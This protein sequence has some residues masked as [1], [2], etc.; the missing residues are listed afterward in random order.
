MAILIVVLH[1]GNFQGF[2]FLSS[3]LVPENDRTLSVSCETINIC[4]QLVR[5]S[6]QHSDTLSQILGGPS[7]K[8]FNFSLCVLCF[9]LASSDSICDAGAQNPSRVGS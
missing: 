7:S 2:S 1:S 3:C 5:T 4:N 9:S 6:S 8:I